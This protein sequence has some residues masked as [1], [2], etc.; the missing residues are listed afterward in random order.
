MRQL[1]TFALIL[2][3]GLLPAQSNSRKLEL[4]R[5]RFISDVIAVTNDTADKSLR[6][7]SYLFNSKEFQDSIL[8]L[9]FP[10]A[11][12]CADCDNNS[13]NTNAVIAGKEILDSVFRQKTIYLILRLLPVGKP[14][15][16]FFGKKKCWGLGNTCPNTDSITSFYKNIDCDM[17]DDLPFSYA[18][19]VHLCH[20][21]LHDVGYC[22]TDNDIVDDIAEAV[23]WIAFYYINKWYHEG[24]INLSK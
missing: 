22:H 9:K 23:G 21:Y 12:H 8:K 15:L 5:K 1:L 16:S 3:P 19:A 2:F 20:E 13:D 24:T 10:F 7:A 17:G 6:I 18:Y 4:V 11:N 14:P